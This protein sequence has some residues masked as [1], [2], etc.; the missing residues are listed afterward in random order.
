[1]ISNSLP[2]LNHPFNLSPRLYGQS[3]RKHK[4]INKKNPER[5]SSRESTSRLW[6]NLNQERAILGDFWSL[7]WTIGV[8][9]ESVIKIIFCSRYSWCSLIKC[10]TLFIFV[11]RKED[12]QGEEVEEEKEEV[13]VEEEK[14]EVGLHVEEEKEEVHVE[15]KE[16]VGL[17]VEEEKEEVH[18][19]EEKEEVHV[20]E[21]KEEVHVQCRR[22]KR[23]SRR[24]IL[25]RM[26]RRRNRK[27]GGTLH[28]C[29]IYALH[30]KIW[31]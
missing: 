11:K 23:R 25:R 28:V 20:E 14:E 12:D 10:H 6:L 22:R 26:K 15:E 19:E 3:M 1:M 13:H 31:L 8:V 5:F 16:E 9:P 18:V 2:L 17:H 29:S 27:G 21:E 7:K 30:G 4:F 24:R